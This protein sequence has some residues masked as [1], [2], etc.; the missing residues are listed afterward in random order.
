MLNHLRFTGSRGTLE[1][2]AVSHKHSGAHYDG[3]NANVANADSQVHM[4]Y[5]VVPGRHKQ[6]QT[7]PVAMAKGPVAVTTVPP[8]LPLLWC[9]GR[10]GMACIAA[11][12]L[13]RSRLGATE[14]MWVDA[15]AYLCSF[16][17]KMARFKPRTVTFHSINKINN[18]NG[19]FY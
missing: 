6:H 8:Q 5:A 7:G 2:P 18:Q 19:G 11:L 4:C 16:G 9:G 12:C 13:G 17:S 1:N 3:A 10:A 15:D 14:L